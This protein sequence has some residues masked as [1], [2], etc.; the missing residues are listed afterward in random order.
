VLL[1]DYVPFFVA[2]IQEFEKI[3]EGQQVEID[4]LSLD[5]E[6]LK[7]QCFV[8]T[9]TWGIILWEYFVGI[10]I[11]NSK[12]IEERRSRI[13]AKLRG[14]GTSTVEVIKQVAQSFI[15]DDKVDIIEDN[16]NYS[17]TID[18]YSNKIKN[19]FNIESAINEIKP[20]HLDYKISI[21][22]EKTLLLETKTKEYPY[23][24]YMCGTF[25]CGTKP[26]IDNLGINV[27]AELKANTNN[28]STKQKYS[29]A[30]T[31]ESGGDTI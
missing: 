20:A 29:I 23:P 8:L 16:F 9:A 24:W 2:E 22:E 25:L 1:K 30:G 12:S 7:K 19:L 5:I 13:L 4:Q 18:F 31:F 14:Q 10:Q 6:D 28:K 26:D 3:Y 17:F 27:T 11:D 21:T 15:S